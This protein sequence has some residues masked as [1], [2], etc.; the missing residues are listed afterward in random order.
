MPQRLSRYV[1]LPSSTVNVMDYGGSGPLMVLIHGLGG[2]IANWDVV[3]PRWAER[4]RVL[5]LDLPG[6]GLSPPGRDWALE[7]LEEAVVEL[8]EHLGG[9]ALVVGNS[10][11]GL[12][13]EMVAAH[14]PDVVSDLVLISPATPPR[15]PDPNVDW[16]MATRLLLNSTPI[17]GPAISRHL[18]KTVDPSDLVNE[19][20]ARITHKRGRV[21]L[22]LVEAFI[23][24]AQIRRGYPWAPDAIPKTGQAIRKLFLRP[25]GFVEM[26][27][28]ITA[29]TLVIQ[30]VS[31]PIVSPHSV[32][33]LCSLRP[34]W[35]LIHMEDTGHTPHIDSPVR[36]LSVV[37]PWL[38]A[39]IQPG[40]A[41][42]GQLSSKTTGRVG[43]T[44]RE[45][46][47]GGAGSSVR[48]MEGSN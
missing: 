7:T 5:A 48:E 36:F 33:W 31:D 22:E 10:M 46:S 38:E 16:A 14:R 19:S 3:A 20:L 26:I 25:S 45:A 15:L 42:T 9:R 35:K 11:G 23:N 34:D 1:D 41:P 13:A 21:P 17:V 12:I 29:P 4:C 44:V 39:A 18:F 28:Q 32:T 43:A 47:S 27:R 8:I 30:G 6:F 40:I 2:S 37:D 24:I